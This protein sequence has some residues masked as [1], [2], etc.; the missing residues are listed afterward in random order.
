VGSDDRVPDEDELNVPAPDPDLPE[1]V[2]DDLADPQASS[3]IRAAADMLDEVRADLNY[4][5]LDIDDA[6]IE[7]VVARIDGQIGELQRTL[8]EVSVLAEL[9]EGDEDAE[10][11]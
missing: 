5:D 4:G 3:K 7:A 2:R 1:Q 11:D 8:R 9:H 10:R 6:E